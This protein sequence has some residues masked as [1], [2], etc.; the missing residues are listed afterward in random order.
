M[1]VILL[2]LSLLLASILTN[3]SAARQPGVK[4]YLQLVLASDGSSSRPHDAKPVGPKLSEKL[5]SVFKWKNYWELRRDSMVVRQG[6]KVRKSMS[7]EHAV[8]L[9]LLDPEKVGIRIFLNGELARTRTQ[10]VKNAF[11]VTGGRHIKD[12]SLSWFVVV[13]TDEPQKLED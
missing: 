6:E 3:H 2:C 9:E 5:S 10:P 13:R 4:F 7:P 11:C 1:R 12:Q 8:E